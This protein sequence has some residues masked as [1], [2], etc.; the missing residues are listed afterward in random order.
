M[1]ACSR[2]RR[3]T[4]R[5]FLP[6]TRT[7][8]RAMRRGSAIV[9]VPAQRGRAAGRELAGGAPPGAASAVAGTSGVAGSGPRSGGAPSRR[10]TPIPTSAGRHCSGVSAGSA[11]HAST[12]DAHGVTSGPMSTSMN[13]RVEL[14]RR[15][16]ERACRRP[17][18]SG[19]HRASAAG[20]TSRGTAP[21]PAPRRR[22]P[23]ARHPHGRLRC[24]APAAERPAARRAERGRARRARSVRDGSAAASVARDAPLEARHARAAEIRPGGVE[25][26]RQRLRSRRLREHVRRREAQPQP[27]CR[28]STAMI[29]CRRPRR[30]GQERPHGPQPEPPPSRHRATLHRVPGGA[31]AAGGREATPGDRWPYG[32]VPPEDGGRLVPDHCRDRAIRAAEPACCPID[33]RDRTVPARALATSRS[34][35]TM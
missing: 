23:V 18:R 35:A 25:V 20:P 33:R 5:A 21:P 34:I 27:R 1:T 22:G 19:R 32:T 10:P 2:P 17:P 6:A 12:M 7:R 14:S 30:G 16:P 31:K 3:R 24:G 9:T 11:V 13:S 28:G 4:T 8:A 29:V 15:C 26:Q